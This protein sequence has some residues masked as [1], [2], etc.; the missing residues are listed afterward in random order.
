LDAP[1]SQC[2]RFGEKKYFS[3]QELNPGLQA[4]R[5]ASTSTELSWLGIVIV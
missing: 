2:G 4:H 5:E 1:Q 3:R